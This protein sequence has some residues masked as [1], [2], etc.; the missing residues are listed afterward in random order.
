MSLLTGCLTED[1]ITLFA[2]IISIVAVFGLVSFIYP[3]FSG[4]RCGYSDSGQACSGPY[5]VCVDGWTCT[6]ACQNMSD[7]LNKSVYCECPCETC[8][9]PQC[10]RMNLTPGGHSNG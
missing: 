3:Y 1:T 4:D 7:T 10:F 5:G 2:L 8:K 6:V 9:T